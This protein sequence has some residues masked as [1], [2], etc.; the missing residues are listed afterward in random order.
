MLIGIVGFVFV[1]GAAMAIAFVARWVEH[2]GTLH[3]WN[4]LVLET[5]HALVFLAD[6]IAFSFLI[7]MS[8]VKLLSETWKAYKP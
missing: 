8:C 7:L 3:A 6:A 5:M 1:A 2:A 4:L